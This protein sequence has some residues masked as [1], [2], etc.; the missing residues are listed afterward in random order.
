[1]NQLIFVVSLPSNHSFDNLFNAYSNFETNLTELNRVNKLN[2]LNRSIDQ[3]WTT[4]TIP[5]VM[6]YD[7]S[8][9]IILRIFIMRYKSFKTL[10]LIPHNHQLLS[11]HFIAQFADSS[12]TTKLMRKAPWNTRRCVAALLPIF[13]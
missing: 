7:A 4:A 13:F 1:M 2:K 9:W 11:T 8:R 5:P 10:S 3:I 6:R 12:R